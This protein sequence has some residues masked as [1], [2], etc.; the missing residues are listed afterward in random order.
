MRPLV[1]RVPIRGRPY[2]LSYHPFG[3]LMCNTYAFIC[4]ST[5]KATIIDP[6]CHDKLE[7]SQL[8]SFLDGR[9]VSHILLTHGHADHVAG[10]SNAVDR[11]PSASLCMHP[12]E[13]ENYNLGHQHSKK[14]GL[15]FP[16]KLPEPNHALSEGEVIHIGDTIRLKVLETPGHAPGHVAFVDE[17]KS[18]DNDGAV[19]IGGDL[20]FRGSVGR[21]DFFNSCPE[22]L[23]ASLRRLYEMYDSESIVLSGH[24]TPTYLKNERDSNVF[25]SMALQRPE[26]W[27]IEETKRHGWVCS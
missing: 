6:A 3:S 26:E 21:T 17:D 25:V 7:F 12:L 10:V 16:S 8:E 23:M 11:W 15:N 2:T 20:L 14:F 19:I 24:T 1:R 4:N 22:A 18:D 13:G 5:N 27:W 9:D